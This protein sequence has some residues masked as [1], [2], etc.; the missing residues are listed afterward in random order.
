MLRNNITNNVL[1]LFCVVD[2]ESTPFSVDID[3][4][5]T[6][7]H[8]KVA[9]KDKKTN[10]FGDVDADKL[11]LWQVSIPLAPL[12][13]RKPII[14]NEFD[15]AIKLDPTAD[16]SD[17]FKETPPKKSIQVIVQ[18]PPPVQTPLA[19]PV[20]VRARSFTSFSDEPHPGT[21]LS[22]DRRG[23]L[24]IPTH[25]LSMHTVMDIPAELILLIGNCLSR[26]SVATCARVCKLWHRLLIPLLYR[27]VDCQQLGTIPIEEL[28][29]NARHIRRLSV[30]LLEDANLM[31]DGVSVFSSRTTIRCRSLRALSVTVYDNRD[32]KSCCE[33]LI[34]LNQQ[35][36]ELKIS[37][38]SGGCAIKVDIK[39]QLSWRVIFSQCSPFL[40]TLALE[41]CHLSKQETAL[42]ME[43]GRN[44][45]SLHIYDCECVWSEFTA[46]P[47]FPVMTCLKIC[48]VFRSPDQ[49][50]SWF[51]QCPRLETISWTR[52]TCT[53]FNPSIDLTRPA[54]STLQSGSWKH[55]QELDLNY[56]N[57]SDSQLA[58]IL[59]SCGPLRVISILKSGFWYRSL[60]ALEKHSE[61]LEK[62]RLHDGDGLHSWMCQWIA[63]SFP[64]LTTLNVG[65]VFAHELVDDPSAEEAQSKQV[66]KNIRDDNVLLQNEL[67]AR[68]DEMMDALFEARSRFTTSRISQ[69]VRPWVCLKLE[70]LTM[71]FTF[72][73]D[74]PTV[75]WD[76]QVFQQIS[77]LEC[78]K[79][80]NLGPSTWIDD[81]DYND[82][83]A[84]GVYSRGLQLQVQSGLTLLAPLKNLVS[85]EF[86]DTNQNMDEQDL[87]WILNQ[88]PRLKSIGRSLHK[89]K[90]RRVRLWSL[91]KARGVKL[92]VPHFK[93][94]DESDSEEGFFTDYSEFE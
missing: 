55:L 14:L 34:L 70:H 30:R 32:G 13:E 10:D 88:W 64:N 2:S 69:G 1:T 42:L 58:H 4:S 21:A 18:R 12:N 27:T 86:T 24:P 15:F 5:K 20:L 43:L 73:L 29:K 77:K 85:L 39:L 9:I 54:F 44:L 22:V 19:V 72:L 51:T 62:L 93:N 37:I 68:D 59:T 56:S 65:R 41:H 82:F 8:L 16:V 80:L 81:D 92:L 31:E 23:F 94:E 75:D 11:T 46:E 61:T 53:T 3:P 57:L 67:A 45:K 17:V 63:S 40:Q 6:V 49:E 84:P 52:R 47:Q 38:I 71:R 7:D 60:S 74:Q 36:R 76:N 25:D 48:Q 78:L 91:A 83:G 89:D 35:L 79:S 33:A 90:A 87:L 50:V 26:R 66:A 28:E